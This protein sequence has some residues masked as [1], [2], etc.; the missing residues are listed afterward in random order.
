L[1]LEFPEVF[2]RENPGFDV[3]VGNPPFVG[4]Q[5]ITGAL[6]TAYRDYLIERIAHGKKG[7]ADLCAY[8]FLR[9]GQLV[10][11]GGMMALLATNTIAQ[12]DTREV[13]LDQL[14]AHGFSIPRAVPSTPWPGEASLEVA[15]VWL[16]R[17]AWPGDFVLN[18]Q[19]VAGITPFLTVPGQVAGNPYRL[20]ANADQSFQGSIVLGM[21]FVLTPE[22]AH[23]LI[24]RNPDHKDCL[25]PYLNG[26]DLNSRFDQSPSR[27]VINFH[28]WPLN[29]KADGIWKT[30]DAKRRKTWLQSGMVSADY[31]DPVAADYPELLAIVEEK[32][33]PERD[34]LNRK[35][36]R[37][38]WW[39]YAERA[40]KLYSTIA[41]LGRVLVCG[42]VTTHLSF[43]FAKIPVVFMHKLAVFPFD[44][45][46]N[47][48]LLQSCI[49]E[50][51][52][53]HYS[54][55]LAVALNY[56]PSDCFETFPFPHN[57]AGL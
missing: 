25:F 9:A 4:G 57:L 20:A 38:R 15:Q 5:K 32:A 31:P 7:S 41:G 6:G 36:R 49:H 22:E 21:G 26:E 51:W 30:A 12:G 23:A 47:F 56:S 55:T 13:G 27:W 19:P 34:K 42:L 35:A 16:Y 44:K 8:F 14:T 48:A 3:I 54:S 43:G 18:E 1:E 39:Q 45:S 37:D 52:T 11:D 53:R 17:G 50:I 40:P 2:G 29:R 28:D 10:R 46:E 24:A 33:K